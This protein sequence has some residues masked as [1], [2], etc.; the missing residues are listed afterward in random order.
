M[1]WRCIP[2]S[3]RRA[4]CSQEGS[5]LVESLVGIGLIG[6]LTAAV[7]TLLPAVLEA[8]VRAA[9]HQS[10][11]MVADVLLEAE[12]AGIDAAVL[13]PLEIRSGLRVTPEIVPADPGASSLEEPC[14]RPTRSARNAVR[15]EHGGRSDGRQV[16][17]EAAAA[18]TADD[19]RSLTLRWGGE[20]RIAEGLQLLLPDGSI[21]SPTA[22]TSGCSAFDDLPAGTAWVSAPAGAPLLIDGMHVPLVDRPHAVTLTA[23]SHDRTLDLE[24]AA[25]LSVELDDGGARRPDHVG[26]GALRWLVRGDEADVATDAGLA[27][28]VHP[29]SVTAV[30]PGCDD[31]A[32]TGSAA[33]VELLPG[34]HAVVHVPLAV[35]TVENLGGRTGAWLQLQR[36]T[37]CADGQALLPD[38]R[39][40]G[41]L[42][43]G[44][45]IAIPRGEW[46]AWLREP[47][48]R[49]QT[50]SIRFSAS[51]TETVVRLP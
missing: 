48:G 8:R 39:F 15:I 35:V 1:R 41:D 49:P 7:A 27:R 34:E 51:G 17:L 44:M 42:H 3:S 19:V 5:L 46:F 30:V 33:T 36:S 18:L 22:E 12:T 29:G 6:A 47:A 21:G 32:A 50:P 40:E 24:E 14:D 43:E 45:R 37:A 38:L 13:P 25:W 26:A 23:R 4:V 28:P 11:L 20:G 16:V 9:A 10:A 31:S 2:P